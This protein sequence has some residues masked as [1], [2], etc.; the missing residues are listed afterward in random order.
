MAGKSQVVPAKVWIRSSVTEKKLQELVGDGLLRPRMSQDLPEWR[1]PLTNHREPSPLEGYMVSFVAFHERGLGAPPSQF[2]RAIL[3]YYGMEIHH[4]APN[5][6][7]QATIFM[8][9]CEGYLGIEP[10]WKLWLHLFKAEHFAKKME[11]RGVRQAVHARSCTIQVPAS[12][13]E[14]YILA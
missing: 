12:R 14:L 8:V 10:H 5:S 6:I 2:M 7:S 11:E 13:G 3:Y 1:V 9:V 4:L